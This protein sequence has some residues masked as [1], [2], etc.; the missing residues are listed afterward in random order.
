MNLYDYVASIPDFPSKG[1]IFRDIT[2]VMDHGE[3]FKYACDQLI[4]YAKRI[5][6]EVVVGPE[7][8]GFAFGTPISYALNIGFVP[9]RKPGKLPLKTISCTYDLEYM[10]KHIVANKYPKYEINDYLSAICFDNK[11]NKDSFEYMIGDI[12]KDNYYKD[13]ISFLIEDLV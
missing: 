11:I 7:A 4:E 6:A 5:G 12:K 3:A 8:R 2:P 1:I 9:V 13:K 10:S